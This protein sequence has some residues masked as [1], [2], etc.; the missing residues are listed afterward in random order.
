[1]KTDS[2]EALPGRTSRRGFLTK[3]G[4]VG[5]AVASAP[6]YNL[7]R[8]PNAQAAPIPTICGCVGTA[9]CNT[10]NTSIYCCS[11]PNGTNNCPS[12]TYKSGWWRCND[13][14]P[15]MCGGAYRYYIDCNPTSGCSCNCPNGCNGHPSCKFARDY[16]NCNGDMSLSR[17]RCRIVRCSNPGSIWPGTCST[18]GGTLSD[19]SSA[20]NCEANCAC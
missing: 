19:S 11:M 5:A 13:V 18:T 8:T 17:I 6:I 12:G 4:R 15:A 2:D 3:V 20:C 1:M 16:T 7:L 9:P 14:D 10:F